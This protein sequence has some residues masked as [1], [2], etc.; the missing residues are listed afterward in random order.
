VSPEE[1][2]AMAARGAFLEHAQVFGNRYGTSREAR[3]AGPRRSG[4][5]EQLAFGHGET[6]DG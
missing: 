6:G 5:D 4:E 1:F 3:L 2:E